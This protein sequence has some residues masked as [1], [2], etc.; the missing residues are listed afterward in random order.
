MIEPPQPSENVPPPGYDAQVRG[1]HD[2]GGG[3]GG[4]DMPA[5]E[6]WSST[7]FDDVVATRPSAP[8]DELQDNVVGPPRWV[9]LV[10]R[11]S[12]SSTTCASPPFS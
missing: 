2:G 10:A 3:G 11:A 9:E 7:P 6:D 12:A 8:Y 5:A 1:V 4:D